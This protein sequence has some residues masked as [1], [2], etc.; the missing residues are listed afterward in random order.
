MTIQNKQQNKVFK[1]K[2]FHLTN[3]FDC[4]CFIILIVNTLERLKSAYD[5][6]L[7]TAQLECRKTA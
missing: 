1:E 6:R 3:E 2:I 5:K 7:I 4:K